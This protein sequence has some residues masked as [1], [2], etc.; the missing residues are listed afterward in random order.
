MNPFPVGFFGSSPEM[1]W[2]AT[3]GDHITL[4]NG[5]KTQTFT[6]ASGTRSNVR[7]TASKSSGKRQVDIA[8]VLASTEV[9]FGVVA[10][11]ATTA[12]YPGY[13]ANGLGIS[14]ADGHIYKNNA[15][16]ASFVGASSASG[17][18]SLVVDFSAG[19]MTLYNSGGTV[20]GVAYTDSIISS[21]A[22]FVAAGSGTGTVTGTVSATINGHPVTLYGGAIAWDTA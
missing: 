4:S 7:T 10:A 3:A 13:D 8:L 6:T 19:T 12:Q 22:M 1:V 11:S 5:N 18:Y 9:L 15:S 17:T 14:T 21:N 20:I 2:S 16:V